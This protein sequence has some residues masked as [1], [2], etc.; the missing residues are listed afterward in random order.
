MCGTRQRK[1]VDIRSVLCYLA[2]RKLKMRC[3]SVFQHLNVSS[4]AVS[5][6]VVRGNAILSG[7][8]SEDEL[9]KS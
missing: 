3:L 7:T 6:S 2:V 5:K 1:V 4:S 8:N 9:L